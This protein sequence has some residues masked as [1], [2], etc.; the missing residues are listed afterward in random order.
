MD[1]HAHL[2]YGMTA[3]PAASRSH[4]TALRCYNN[5]GGLLIFSPSKFLA[6]SRNEKQ[7][8]PE[9]YQ[10]QKWESISCCQRRENGKVE[11]GMKVY[12]SLLHGHCVDDQRVA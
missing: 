8:I 5:A 9:S 10:R 6:G 2:L 4:C 3:T 12:S 1:Y 11:G 7:L